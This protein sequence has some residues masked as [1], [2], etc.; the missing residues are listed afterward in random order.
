MPQTKELPDEDRREELDSLLADLQRAN[1][2]LPS[3]GDVAFAGAADQVSAAKAEVRTAID[4][5]RDALGSIPEWNDELV[6]D[7]VLEYATKRDTDVRRVD[8]EVVFE[9]EVRQ[10][11]DVVECRYAV[12]ATSG[13]E[14][15][16]VKQDGDWEEVWSN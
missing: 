8:S 1:E 12:A 16:H 2:S 3:D 10:Y 14:W 6:R 13:N 9:F 11:D 5:V 7:L 15:F 4:N